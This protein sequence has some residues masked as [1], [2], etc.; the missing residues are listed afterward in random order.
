M[1]AHHSML[2]VPI[3]GTSQT[4]V[5]Q[6]KLPPTD[7]STWMCPP[8]T[9]LTGIMEELSLKNVLESFHDAQ[10]SMEIALQ[11]FSNGSLTIE[12]RAMA[13]WLTWSICVKINSFLTIS[14][15]SRP[16]WTSCD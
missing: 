6:V 3:V 11:M 8:L 15:S 13:E 9:E 7:K 4:N 10:T 16:S 12:Q 14:S 1:V 2:I 5:E